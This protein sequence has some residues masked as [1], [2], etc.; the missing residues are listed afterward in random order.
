MRKQISERIKLRK[1]RL[2]SKHDL[3]SGTKL[4][5]S[6]KIEK[7]VSKFNSSKRSKDGL[8]SYCKSCNNKKR[9]NWESTFDGFLSKIFSSVK[10]KANIKYEFDI[11]EK[12]IITLLRNTA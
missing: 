7:D 4:C 11:T 6:C 10:E 3:L 8:N 1:K 12:D 2:R 9:T 5:F